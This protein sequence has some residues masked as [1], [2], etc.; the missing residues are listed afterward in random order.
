MD[1]EG[2]LRGHPRFQSFRLDH[3]R[4]ID[5]DLC[6]GDRGIADVFPEQIDQCRSIAVERQIA[7]YWLEGDAVA[8]SAV[9]PATLL[10]GC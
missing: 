9:N 1:F 3:L 2:F 7:A 5:G 6:L 4:L 10:T 8:Y